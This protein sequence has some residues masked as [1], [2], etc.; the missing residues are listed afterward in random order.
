MALPEPP[1]TVAGYDTSD[2]GSRDEMLTKSVLGASS[3][4]PPVSGCSSDVGEQ[5]SVLPSETVV[6]VGLHVPL[7]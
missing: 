3:E 7:P 4:T 1:T 5:L 6:P 2:E